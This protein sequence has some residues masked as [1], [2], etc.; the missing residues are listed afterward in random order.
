LPLAGDDLG[1]QTHAQA[2]ELNYGIQISPALL[3]RPELEYL[4][5]PVVT[6]A[7]PNFF[8][9]GLKTLGMGLERR[10]G[11]QAALV[12]TDPA[13]MDAEASATVTRVAPASST[14]SAKR[15]F[16]EQDHTR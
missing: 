12:R 5:R 13:N 6:G 9:V 8:L 4:I 15:G 11:N 14:I 2:P 16:H 10:A 3:I 1:V 7:V